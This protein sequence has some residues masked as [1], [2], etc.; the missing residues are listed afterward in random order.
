MIFSKVTCPV[1]GKLLLY[2]GANS[3]GL[4]RVFCKICKQEKIIELGAKKQC[5]S[6]DS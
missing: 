1:C 6:A 3:K 5:N 4:V 2:S